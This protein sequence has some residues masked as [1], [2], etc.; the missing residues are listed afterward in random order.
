[1][2]SKVVASEFYSRSLAV[3]S[4]MNVSFNMTPS[5]SGNLPFEFEA[6]SSPQP[7][8]YQ[9]LSA[10]TVTHSVN[11]PAYRTPLIIGVVIAI[12]VVVGIV[13]YRISSGG[14]KESK[15][16]AIKKVDQ[17]KNPPQKKQ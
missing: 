16:T 14:S 3:G 7:S 1:V 13:Y 8:F 15:T 10:F 9:P 6:G 4:S 17:K 5:A 11:P 12:I 2:N